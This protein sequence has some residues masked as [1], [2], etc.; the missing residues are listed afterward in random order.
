MGPR[1]SSPT[2]WPTTVTPPKRDSTPLFGPSP[3]EEFTHSQLDMTLWQLLS[4]GASVPASELL[5]YSVHSFRI[6]AACS[7]LAAGAP[8]WTIKRLLHWRGDDSLEIYARINDSEWAEWT[9]KA[10]GAHVES[11]IASRLAY[12]DFSETE[13]ARMN[14]IALAMLSLD[15][16][17]A[18]AATREL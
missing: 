8:R 5:N 12:M 15:A 7:L 18:R 13:E 11:S 9:A 1:Q 14:D 2:S 3:G 10:R 6:Y 4:H 17:T 16:A